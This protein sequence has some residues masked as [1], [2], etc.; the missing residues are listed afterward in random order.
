MNLAARKIAN[1]GQHGTDCAVV[2]VF[3]RKRLPA[4]TQQLDRASGGLVRAALDNGDISGEAGQSLLLQ[5]PAKCPARRA[6]LLGCG[7]PGKLD[8]GAARKLLGALLKALDGC[9]ARE[10]SLFFEELPGPELPGA[11]LCE[12]L[13]KLATTHRYAYGETLSKPP[14]AA[15]A[16]KLLVQAGD[17]LPVRACNSALRRGRQI[18]EGINAARELGNLPGNI[19]TPAY[20]AAQARKLGRRSEALSVSV[21]DEAQMKRLGMGALLS[22][23]AGSAQPAKLIVMRYQGGGKSARPH[24]LIGKGITFDSGGI[25]LKPG[26]KMDEMKFDM[27]GAASVLGAMGALLDMQLA[28]NV[29]GIVAAS[30]NLPSG[31]ATKPG[32][33]VTSMSGQTIEILNTDAEGRLVL[34]DALTYA[35]RFRP[36]AVIDI[37]TL[38]G[39]CLVALGT[40]ASGLYA[41]DEQLAQRL[42]AA[43]QASHDRAWRMPLWDD[44]QKQIDSPFADVANVGGRDGGSITAA[45][46]LARFARQYRWAHMDIAGT[47]WS[48]SPKGATGRPVGLLLQYLLERA[49]AAGP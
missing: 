23:S 12:L 24:V 28:I 33:I 49:G 9:K 11:A 40:H 8:A 1:A 32:D 47:A 15:G 35:G 29:V 44:Y 42:L 16:G 25:S 41:N 20:L 36:A 10:A 13:G 14:R 34:C 7:K 18:G 26:A 38:T 21:L 19:C 17:W 2:P 48:N 22:V 45:C 30:E 5:L 43:G 31:S 3:S 4:A 46:F 6:L 27:C 39:A 37:A